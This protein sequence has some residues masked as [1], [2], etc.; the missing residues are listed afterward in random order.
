VQ[1]TLQNLGCNIYVKSEKAARRVMKSITGFIEVDLKLK[2]SQ[3]KSFVGRPWDVKFLGFSFYFAKDECRVRVHPKVVKRFKAKLKELTGRS[4]GVSMDSRLSRLWL[5]VVGWVN[6][7]GVAD[8][9]L[10]ARSLDEWVRRRIRMVFWKSWKLLWT[11][12]AWLQRLGLDKDTA[13]A[14]ANTRKG[15]WRVS[16]SPILHYILTNRV[17]EQKYGLVSIYATYL[18]VNS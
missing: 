7:F 1:K 4:K 5:A 17:L 6:Y 12:F 11:R 18:S 3:E 2:V 9:K 16:G 15:Y 10:L 8:M 13:W 14:Y